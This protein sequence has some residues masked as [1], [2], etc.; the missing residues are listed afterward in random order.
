[1]N[2]FTRLL[3]AT[4]IRGIYSERISADTRRYYERL[5]IYSRLNEE[6]KK[7]TTLHSV[8]MSF[9]Y[10]EINYQLDNLATHFC[11]QFPLVTIPMKF[12]Q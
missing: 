4:E 6:H 5:T 1:M 11:A 3:W 2:L 8:G 9:E 10:Q 12:A 7:H